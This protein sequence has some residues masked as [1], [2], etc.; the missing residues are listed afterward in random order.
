MN[1]LVMLFQF[2]QNWTASNFYGHFF[3][4]K[5]SSN[6]IFDNSHQQT[7]SWFTCDYLLT[8]SIQNYGSLRSYSTVLERLFMKILDGLVEKYKQMQFLMNRSMN[9]LVTIKAQMK[10][11]KKHFQI[12]LQIIQLLS[13]TLMNSRELHTTTQRKTITQQ[14]NTRRPKRKRK[15][16]HNNQRFCGCDPDFQNSFLLK[17]NKLVN[18]QQR[19]VCKQWLLV[20]NKNLL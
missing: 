2:Q 18:Q 12:F 11:Y 14:N 17:S 8:L 6:V 4:L 16:K 10:H 9:G 13:L 20:S 5:R 1:K 15:R 19:S 7:C 3:I